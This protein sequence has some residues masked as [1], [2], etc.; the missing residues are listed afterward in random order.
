M[1][2]VQRIDLQAGVQVFSISWDYTYM[3]ISTILE[4]SIKHS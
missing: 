2:A 4:N 3:P 1:L